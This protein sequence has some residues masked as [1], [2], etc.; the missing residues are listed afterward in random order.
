MF[1]LL[2]VHSVEVQLEKLEEGSLEEQTG[3]HNVRAATSH[4]VDSVEFGMEF[5][6]VCVCQLAFF[7]VLLKSMGYG[8]PPVFL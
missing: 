8:S 3:L 5:P 6:L 4:R 1:L 2:E 7:I